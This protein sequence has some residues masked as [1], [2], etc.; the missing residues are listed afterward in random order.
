MRVQ[1]VPSLTRRGFVASA[2]AGAGALALPRGLV[3]P[4]SAAAAETGG[5]PYGP[6]WESLDSH[7][8]P[9]WFEDA[10]L[11][12]FIH[13]GLFAVPAWG[14]R[15]TYAEWYPVYMKQLT[16]QTFRHHLLTYGGPLFAYRDFIP[17]WRA[18]L[19][20]PDAWA[21]L[22]RRAGA[23][24]VVPVAE[25]HDGFPLWDS[26]LTEWNSV[27]M[28]PKRDF[29]RELGQATRSQGM[30][31]GP[32]Y[33]AYLSNYSPQYDG[34][35]PRY[36][37][38]STRPQYM[39]YTNEKLRELIEVADSDIFWLDGDWNFS[40]DVY[41]TRPTLAWYY[42][43]AHERGQ[44]VAANDRLGQVRGKHGDF[45][46]QE[47]DYDTNQGVHHKWENTRG[48]GFSFGFNQAEP[49][50]DYLTLDALVWM[51]VDNVAH[52]ANL[53][54]NVGPRG[55][56]TINDIQR[57]LLLGLGD[58]L[59]TNGEAIYG[60]RAHTVQKGTTFEG[61]DVRY[62]VPGPSASSTEKASLYALVHGSPT[63][64]GTVAFRADQ[65]PALGP[66]QQVRLLG[67]PAPLQWVHEGDRVTVVMPAAL[68]PQQPVFTVRFD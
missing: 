29:V 6:T 61:L 3:R 58:W 18:E 68:P 14:P 2:L 21:D 51:F 8:I 22:F 32:S 11:G 33:H 36:G 23:R 64:G 56:G 47:Y 12:I 48:M 28:G 55:D 16:H 20:D 1:P 63:P 66:T 34:P 59:Q 57:D 60:S 31:Y 40:S 67:H 17:M 10:K 5:A 7:P 44:L 39:A 35:D 65:V 50:E 42:N 15:G 37:S 13:W 62:T 43:R 53:L 52:G 30:K 54:L 38:A 25:H 26:K 4:V 46:T 45:Y 19:W 27:K 41:Q 24:Y 9:D 49:P